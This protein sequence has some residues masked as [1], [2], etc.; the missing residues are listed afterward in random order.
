MIR[1]KKWAEVIHVQKK[2]KFLK[3]LLESKDAAKGKQ[4]RNNKAFFFQEL[5]CHKGSRNSFDF[6][7]TGNLSRV[8]YLH[9]NFHLFFYIVFLPKQYSFVKLIILLKLPGYQ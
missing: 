2:A 4:E 8:D 1:R 6:Q 3:D 9:N 7:I 5:Y